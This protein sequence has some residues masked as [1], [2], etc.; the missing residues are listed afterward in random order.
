[1]RARMLLNP[2]CRVYVSL[3]L[4]PAWWISASNLCQLFSLARN[5]RPNSLPDLLPL[6][7]GAKFLLLIWLYFYYIGSIFTLSASVCSFID[8]ASGIRASHR[9][10]YINVVA[11]F[12]TVY[13]S[14]AAN[15]KSVWEGVRTIKAYNKHTFKWTPSWK[16]IICVVPCKYAKLRGRYTR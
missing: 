11:I 3:Y 15:N 14:S 9:I 12:W 7:H 6:P 13:L 8:G 1:L 2:C 4:C 16:D 5:I 10:L